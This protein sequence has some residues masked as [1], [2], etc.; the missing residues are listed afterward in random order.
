MPSMYDVLPDPDPTMRA[1]REVAAPL[2]DPGANLGVVSVMKN[3][4]LL[5]LVVEREV[6]QR[7]AGSFMGLIWS[8][9]NPLIQFGIYW[10]VMGEILG[11]HKTIPN[12]PIHVFSGFIIAHFF[13]ETFAAGT[14][15]IVSNKSLVEK[16]PVPRE[17]FPVAA[18]LVSFYQVLPAAG[19]LLIADFL[20][21][22]QP[23]W[24]TLGSFLLSMGI[25]GLLGT[26]FALIMAVANVFWRDI[27]SVV[28][29]LNHLVRFGVPMVYS[30]SMMQD[31]FGGVTHVLAMNPLFS[32]VLL[33]QRGFWV[34]ATPHPAKVLATEFPPHL[35]TS[36]LTA[37][38]IAVLVFIAAQLWFTRIDNRIPERLL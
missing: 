23:S 27:A 25:C 10:L 21:G 18:M 38:G 16:L 6:K 15:S 3:T 13:M 1:H 20:C 11:A 22:W 31:R 35:W 29:I 14:H 26:A 8:Y 5:R 24:A 19:I 33:F 9:V 2:A 17:L 7:Y 36:G 12:Y 34:D 32:A 4:Y 37:L 28:G 30:Y